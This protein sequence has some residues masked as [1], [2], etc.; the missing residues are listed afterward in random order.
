MTDFPQGGV[1]ERFANS[2]RWY[3]IPPKDINMRIPEY[4]KKCVVFIGIKTLEQPISQIKYIGT[5]FI[6]SVPSAKIPSAN[7]LFFVTAKHVARKIEKEECY[8]RANLKSGDS[9]IFGLGNITWFFH[10]DEVRPSDVAVYPVALDLS[11]IKEL[12][13]EAIPV[14]GFVSDET[15]ISQGIGE[16][17]EVFMVG[18]FSHHTGNQKNLPII[19]TGTIAM[20]SDELIHT[21][22]FGSIEAYLIEARSIKGLSGSPV[23]VIKQNG[24]KIGNHTVPSSMITIH[25]L[26]LIHG[27][28]DLNPGESVDVE[29]AEGGTDSVN[30]GIAIVIPAKHIL[31]TINCQALVKFREQ[32]E[33]KRIAKNTPKPD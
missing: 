11:V 13:F 12:D 7:F 1:D 22:M 24:I 15:R 32:E 18:L 23:F 26:G 25:V 17:D 33:A 29:D 31:E 27:H 20:I 6:V 30:V 8:L 4:M 21:Q 10:P 5:A 3:L 9:A 28:W 19:R 14:S 16:G 2:K